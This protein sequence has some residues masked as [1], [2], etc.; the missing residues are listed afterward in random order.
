MEG[1]DFRSNRLVFNQWTTEILNQGIQSLPVTI[2]FNRFYMVKS[3]RSYTSW[4]RSSES[5]LSDPRFWFENNIIFWSKYVGK[6]FS[7]FYFGSSHT[8]GMLFGCPQLGLQ[9]PLST[10]RKSGPK[11]KYVHSC[12]L[13]QGSAT[14]WHNSR[15]NNLI[16]KLV[17]P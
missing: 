10:P 2:V 3:W 16:R 6:I 5:E 4:T 14:G 17:N 13:G 9:N 11:P 1:L 15:G 8:K 12:T 7:N